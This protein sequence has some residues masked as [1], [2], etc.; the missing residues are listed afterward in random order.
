MME[1]LTLLAIFAG[2]ITAVMGQRWI[3]NLR[4][5]R[6][7]QEQVFKAL[8]RTRL[9]ATSPEHV[10]ALNLIEL[11]FSTKKRSEKS[12]RDAWSEY[13][14]HL[15]P[16]TPVEEQ[17]NH[18]QLQWA[19]RRD[20]LQTTLLVAM[21]DHLGHD[22][23]RLSVKKG[24]YA[25][26]AHADDEFQIRELRRL[27]FKLLTGE[28]SLSVRQTHTDEANEMGEEIRKWLRRLI[29]EEARLPISVEES[30]KATKASSRKKKS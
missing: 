16:P 1:A 15:G 18:E 27:L 17:S 2:P 30:S 24:A 11:E 14:D 12:V 7:R 4:E 5:R 29:T 9:A 6:R 19:E 8:M 23:T 20:D 22:S 10:Q 26:K 13:L 21:A 3:D 28:A 25:P